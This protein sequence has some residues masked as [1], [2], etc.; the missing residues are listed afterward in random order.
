MPP[1]GKTKKGKLTRHAILQAAVQLASQE[2]LE[3]LTI[4]RLAAELGMSKSGLFAHFGSKESLQLA[5]IEAAS[6][7]FRQAVVR[8]A[9]GHP[10]GLVRL[11]ALCQAFLD[12]EADQVFNGG[13]FFAMVTAEFKNRPGLVRDTLVLRMEDWMSFLGTLIGDAQVAGELED[14]L[15]PG[16]LAL[17]LQALFMGANWAY[18]LLGQDSAIDTT[19]A[20]IRHRLQRLA[21][22]QGAPRLAA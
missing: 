21:T 10:K 2:G 3:P 12:Y 20:S 5:T 8:P 4:G 11:W 9:L 7:V 14:D 22:P 1:S 13:C 18:Q 16:A 17:E 19:R 15:D 6:E